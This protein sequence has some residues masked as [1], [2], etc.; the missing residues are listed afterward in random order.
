MLEV[1]EVSGHVVSAAVAVHTWVGSG[2]LESGYQTCMEI[3]LRNRGLH[4][5]RQLVVPIEYAGTRIELGYRLDLLVER[6]VV[7][8]LKAVS[9][10]LPIHQAQLLSYLRLG[11][12]KVGLLLNFH[13]LRMKDGILRLA[14]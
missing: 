4:F 13:V 11:G 1:N 10:L 8:E 5:D 2:L 14:N 7:V 6:Q 9:K 3:E 12:F